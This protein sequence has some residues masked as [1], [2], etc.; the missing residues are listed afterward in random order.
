VLVG[1]SAIEKVD[2]GEARDLETDLETIDT[3][4]TIAKNLRKAGFDAENYIVYTL[5]D[6]D[7]LIEKYDPD[8]LLFFNLCEHLQGRA[9]D[10]VKITTRLDKLGITY[11]GAPTATLRRSLDKGRAKQVLQ[12]YDIPTAPFQV[13]ERSDEAIAVTLPAIVKPVAEDASVGITRESWCS[14]RHSCALGC[15]TS[16]MCIDN[17]RW[18]RSTS[19]GASSTSGC[20]AMARRTF[21]P[22]PS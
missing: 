1:Y 17:R 13:F 7:R 3:A 15:S 11:T 5:R 18:W 19:S 8:D 2:H 4:E 6:I 20:G 14:T 21:C 9:A 16:W 22:W 12:K 10:D